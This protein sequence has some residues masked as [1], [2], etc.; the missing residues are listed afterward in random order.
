MRNIRIR[1]VQEAEVNDLQ[2]VGKQTFFESFS[3][4][5]SASDME[6]YLKKKFNIEQLLTE[7]RNPESQFFFVEDKEKIIGYL[8]LNMSKAGKRKDKNKTLEI[9]RIYVFSNFQGKGVGKILL[10]KTIEIAKR[11]KAKEVW[12]GVWEENIRAINFY[13]KNEFVKFDKYKF[14]LGKDEQTDIL[15]KLR[16]G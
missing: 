11:E 1:K 3:D 10:E 16:L 12:L 15:M 2:R 5:N 13:K 6:I 9:E 14:M 4:K 8:K 7:L